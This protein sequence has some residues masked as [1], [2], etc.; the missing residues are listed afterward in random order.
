MLD[1]PSGK[2]YHIQAV[3]RRR[4]VPCKLNNAKTNKKHLGQLMDCLSVSEKTANEN[5]W[6]ILLEANYSKTWFKVWKD[7]GYNFLRV[8]SWLRTNAG[9]VPNTC[10]SNGD[11]DFGFY[12]SG[13]RVSN[14]WITWPK[15]G[16]NT[17]KQVLIPHKTT[18]SHDE[19]VKEKSLWE[20][21]ASH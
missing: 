3:A 11:K 1:K 4:P 14:T 10:K 15:E 2:W 17:W 8:W 12:L 20:G 6:V 18:M 9:G 5:S 19:G 7:F 16:D 21:F 13:A